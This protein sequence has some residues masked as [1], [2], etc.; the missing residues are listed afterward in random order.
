MGGAGHAP[1]VRSILGLCLWL[2]KVVVFSGQLKLAHVETKLR[3]E[4][5][6]IT[7]QCLR[8]GTSTMC[9]RKMV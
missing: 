5:G 6:G 2:A 1:K 9:I 8:L 3:M 4:V 7:R